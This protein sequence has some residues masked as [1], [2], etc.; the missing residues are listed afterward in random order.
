MQRLEFL[1]WFKP[2]RFAG[3][4]GNL[5]AGS[6][7]AADAGFSGLDGEDAKTAK[8]NAVTLFEC[9]L[10]FPED[11][12]HGHFGLR[13]G[14]SCLVDNFVYDIEFDQGVPQF[15]IE[16]RNP[17]KLMIV[18]ELCFCQG[19]KRT[20]CGINVEN[21]AEVGQLDWQA[22][23]IRAAIDELES[24]QGVSHDKVAEWLRSWETAKDAGSGHGNSE[25]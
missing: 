13:F 3:R 16:R 24:G 15:R 21:D 18:L 25:G 14:D 10:H 5:G 6:R 17:D 11:S 19:R 9:A 2:Y 20:E 22:A 8:F 7:V 1:A 4:D 23:E 12:F